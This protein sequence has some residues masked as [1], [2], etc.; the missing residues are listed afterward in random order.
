VRRTER[1]SGSNPINRPSIGA[2]AARNQHRLQHAVRS[3]GRADLLMQQKERSTTT[4]QLRHCY[5]V[6]YVCMEELMA[7]KVVVGC[8]VRAVFIAVVLAIAALSTPA[9]HAQDR[10]IIQRGDAVVTAFAGTRAPAT[11]P[12]D[13]HPLDRTFI[14]LQGL[15][16]QIFD[17][18]NLGGGPGGQLADAPVK[19]RAK[20][21]DIGHVFGI[22]FA[23][24]GSRSTPNIFLSASSLY[25]LQLVK[26]DG[27][28][29]R[30]LL[31]GEPG[32]SFMPG[33][34]GPGSG[35]P[36]S[37]YTINGRTGQISLFANVQLEGRPNSAAG[38]G[39][40]AY[41]PRTR[42]LF[43]SDLHT[44]MIH[45][46]ASATSS[47]TAPMAASA[48]GWRRLPT[49]RQPRCRSRTRP[50]TPKMPPPGAMRRR[51][52]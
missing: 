20:A 45:R 19:F 4:G 35:G 40:L 34:F 37:I 13:V 14:D 43:V 38:L 49:T 12:T 31:V 27:G 5:S 11:P 23:G 26:P 33:Q 25:G 2:F 32:A 39:N 36:G 17:L 41:D 42:Q 30:R 50:S 15:T 46:F 52:G 1:A 16:A 51:H 29:L 28:G 6:K 44:G 18:S 3:G 47:I 10:T 7:G 22:A 9:A 8:G 24:D 21:A 48:A